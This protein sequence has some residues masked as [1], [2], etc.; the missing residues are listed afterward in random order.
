MSVCPSVCPFTSPARS[1]GRHLW[2]PGENPGQRNQFLP[3]HEPP[4][5]AGGKGETSFFYRHVYQEYLNI[6]WFPD[7]SLSNL[8]VC[9]WFLSSLRRPV[10]E[11]QIAFLW[12]RFW[13]T[14]TQLWCQLAT[15]TGMWA[16]L[17]EGVLAAAPTRSPTSR[18]YTSWSA[19]HL[20][21]SPTSPHPSASPLSANG[22]SGCAL[23]GPANSG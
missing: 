1:G 18:T 23:L 16:S 21:S 14:T 9:V 6:L 12:K 2:Q 4:W 8:C 22:A 17:K 7:Q 13:K 11:A 5:Q 10:T 15:Q 3:V 19:S 20:G